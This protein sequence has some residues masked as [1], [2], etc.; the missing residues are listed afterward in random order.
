MPTFMPTVVTPPPTSPED[1]RIGHLLQGESDGSDGPRV[2]IIGFPCDVGVARN[3]GR[4]G[5]AEGPEA[6]REW[7]YKFT[8]D[9]R[10]EGMRAMLARSRDWGDL[11]L[12]GDLDADQALLGRAVADVLR[13]GGI[14]VVLGGGHETAYGH[15]Q[16]YAQAGIDVG[17]SNIDAHAD[18]RELKDGLGHSGSPFRQA[19]EHESG[20]CRDYRVAGLQPQSV[21]RPH[22]RFLEEHG[23]RFWFR[24]RTDDSE[25]AG[26]YP[27]NGD[28]YATFCLDALDGAFAPGVSAPAAD[29]LTPPFWLAA[30]ERA[31]GHAAVRSFDVVELNPRFDLDGRTARLAALTAWRF[32]RGLATRSAGA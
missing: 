15:F 18:V 7:L 17:I 4:P 25:L 26:L 14:P 19:L 8:P 23:C 11:E 29:A 2:A 10:V 1:P 12:S 31:G 22:V 16:G 21:S 6:L 3:N 32:F 9:A 27:E 13:D 20:H 5:A 24:D 30:A 28:R